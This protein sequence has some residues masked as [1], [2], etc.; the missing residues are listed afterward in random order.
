MSI[1]WLFCVVCCLEVGLIL[2]GARLIGITV[3]FSFTMLEMDDSRLLGGYKL[4]VCCC[5]SAR[6]IHSGARLIGITSNHIQVCHDR[7]G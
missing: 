1:G 7:H 2:S 6:L 3:T 5:L 4:A